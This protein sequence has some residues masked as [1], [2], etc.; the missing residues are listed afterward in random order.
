MLV[1]MPPGTG[2]VPL[3]VYQSLP[4]DSI[5]I[6]TSPQELVQMIVEKAVR[7]ANLMNVKVAGIVENM[8]YLECPDCG[9]RIAVFGE[10]KVAETA[11]KYGL[12]AYAKIPVNPEIAKLCD[13]G[14]IEELDKNWLENIVKK[15]EA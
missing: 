5:V 4:V 3:T 2:D 14:K 1:D 6:V 7:M 13:A 8:S 15:L 10:S 11:E 12:D 9:K